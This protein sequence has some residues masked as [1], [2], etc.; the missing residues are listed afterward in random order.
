MNRRMRCAHGLLLI[1]GSLL[2]ANALGLSAIGLLCCAA[3]AQIVQDE[4]L[5]D[6]GGGE[7]EPVPLPEPADSLLKLMS[8]PYWTPQERAAMRVEH[9]LW[10][11]E[12]LLEPRLAAR[13]AL[14]AGRPDAPALRAEQAD[15][16]D[17]AEAMLERGELAELLVH[18]DGLEAD[19]EPANQSAEYALVRGARLRAQ[20]LEI[21]GRYEEADQAV[22]PVVRIL[23]DRSL[24]DAD[25]LVEGVQALMVRGRVR[26]PSRG[27]QQGAAASDFRT[28]M[29]L[30]ARAR[31]ELDR[32]SWQARLVEAALLYEK[33]NF[34]E[35]QQA[36]G[37]TLKHNPRAARAWMLLG[38]M[39]IDQFDFDRAT[40]VAD[41]LD[42]LADG[43]SY[44]AALLR[45]RAALRQNDLQLAAEQLDGVLAEM[46]AQ[47]DALHAR[48]A[49]VAS[50]YDEPA[51][52]A[53]LAQIDALNG[54]ESHH[55]HLSVGVRMSEARQ[56]GLSA[57][58]LREAIE[59]QPQSAESW[60][61]LGLMSLQAAEDQQAVDAL[62]QAVRLDPFNTRSVNSLALVE[63][64]T[65]WPVMES[66]HFRVR[67]REGIDE[68][69]AREML[70]V[71]E[72]IHQRVAGP[73][74]FDHE[75]AHK[76]LIELMPD[77]ATFAVRIT[78]MPALHTVA[79]ATGPIIAM[80][81]PQEGPGFTNGTYDWPRVLQHEYGHTVTLSRTRN[82]IPHWFTEA[83]A[84]WVES[85]PRPWSWWTLLASAYKADALFPMS[86]ISLRFVR[87][88]KPSDR[89]QAYA[90]GHWMYEYMV[91]AFGAAA[92]LKL[93]DLYAD[94]VSQDE[95]MRTAMGVGEDEFFERF[96]LWAG[97]QLQ[98][99]GLKLPEGVPS[100]AELARAS[101]VEPPAEG[102]PWDA[103][104]LEQW[105]SEHPEHPQV[106]A[107]LVQSGLA[108]SNNR[109]SV[110]MVPLLRA[111]AKACP[112]D[113]MPHRLLARL[114]LEGQL[115]D[116][117]IEG[118]AH[119]VDAGRT[120][121]SMA[122]EHLEFLDQ[123]ET[124]SPVYARAL[125]ERYARVGAMDQAWE[126]ANRAVTIAPFDPALR[127][128]AATVAV[129]TQRWDEA[130]RMLL[131]LAELEP[132]RPVHQRR[133]DAVRLKRGG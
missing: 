63:Q 79:A 26:G 66:D 111:L 71:L 110:E 82:R 78:G 30:L 10:V 114:A 103:A 24:K 106:L 19:P 49:V 21:M 116:Q 123:Q 90:Q 108:A 94:G 120:S 60:S 85:M 5:H 9:G 43:P 16:L 52:H 62:R 75:P 59:R 113:P 105:R 107:L 95:A 122:I 86:E 100:I 12:D 117:P 1:S 131:A 96:Q 39:A 3:S 93:M 46:P 20:A 98:S 29:A 76:T 125:V 56:Y 128:L 27:D 50:T 72:E 53:L 89:S 130:E 118:V 77:H 67:Y 121:L 126:K 18:L 48:A 7:H 23:L 101:G 88:L 64:L 54:A 33:S 74:G 31:D 14:I 57:E 92:P 104:T 129:Q 65:T 2:S 38:T 97:E 32:H 8:A 132:D 109:P 42:T 68:L 40:A 119:Q 55:A 22:E 6:H 15:P 4:H 99:V 36:I 34:K 70:P 13:A 91:E 124:S 69:L 44:H 87:P 133:L 84:V 112:V 61:E 37:E 11:P 17:V 51:L 41:L 58:F 127:E 47:R 28:L 83:A 102:Q 81:S 80:E 25:V 73:K 115:E 35:A 45:S